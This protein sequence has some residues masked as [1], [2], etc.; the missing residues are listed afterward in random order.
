MGVHLRAALAIVGLVGLAAGAI[1]R[2]QQTAPPGFPAQQRPTFRAGIT[3]VPLEVRVLDR[4][5]RPVTDLQQDEFTI[6]EDGVSQ[7]ITHF[8]RH[9]LVAAGPR[10]ALRARPDAALFDVAPADFRVFLIILGGAPDKRWNT[11]EAIARFV[12]EQLLPQDQIAIIVNGRATDFTTDHESIAQAIDRLG[13]PGPPARAEAGQKPGT[14][15][16]PVF[17]DRPLFAPSAPGPNLGFADYVNAPSK[18]GGYTQL[19]RQAIAYLRYMP[20]EKHI[21]AFTG[22]GLGFSSSEEVKRLAVEA[23]DA[24]VVLHVI[25]TGGIP[26]VGPEF[27]EPLTRP[28]DP[29]PPPRPE[30]AVGQTPGERERP[31]RPQSAAL[32]APSLVTTDNRMLVG[33]IGSK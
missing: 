6:L 27:G 7:D 19:V 21:V 29:P 4:D 1:P 20:G 25:M 17:R 18:S 5:G 24:R 30:I 32:G 16:D 9:L 3:A 2:A 11:G 15:R 12:R 8:S 26:A 10:P 33:P 14:T 28:G 23:S 22:Q 31:A 13:T